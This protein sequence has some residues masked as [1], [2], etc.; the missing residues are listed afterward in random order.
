[1][2]EHQSVSNIRIAGFHHF[3]T[4]FQFTLSVFN[5]LDRYLIPKF[6]QLVRIKY[7]C[8]LQKDKRNIQT[9]KQIT[10]F[11]FKHCMFVHAN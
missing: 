5:W 3:R 11:T 2:T 8:L 4:R 9:N 7:L 10:H 6:M 1:M